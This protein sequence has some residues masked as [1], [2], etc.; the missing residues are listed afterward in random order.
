[1]KIVF[2]ITEN[3]NKATFQQEVVKI[4]TSFNQTE[5]VVKPKFQIGYYPLPYALENYYTKS[6]A[7]LTFKPITY[8][9]D[10][11]E[12]LTNGNITSK[13]VIFNSSNV[14]FYWQNNITSY[15]IYL[16]KANI[17]INEVETIDFDYRGINSSNSYGNT[18]V[19]FGTKTK[20]SNVII[21]NESGTIVLDYQL[22]DFYKKTET[23]SQ[24][25]INTALGLKLD[26]GGYVGTAQDLYDRFEGKIEASINNIPKGGNGA[27]GKVLVNSII[28]EI[29]GKIAIA[30]GV[31]ASE[32][33]EVNG[34]VKSNS[35]K[36]NLPSSITAQPNML[37][38]KPDGSRPTWYNN[39]SVGKDIAFIDDISGGLVNRK[40]VT[41]NQVL[42]PSAVNYA[43]SQITV[44]NHG[45]TIGS[46]TFCG[47]FLNQLSYMNGGFVYIPFEW[48]LAKT[49]IKAIDA[50]TLQICNNAGTAI[51][52]NTADSKNSSIDFT[53]WHI[54]LFGKLI[55][56]VPNLSRFRFVVKGYCIA[57]SINANRSFSMINSSNS[58]AEFSLPA[59]SDIQNSCYNNIDAYIDVKDGFPS[60]IGV[61]NY[62]YHNN[63]FGT[64]AS[65]RNVNII[66]RFSNYS[67]ATSIECSMLGG[68][69]NNFFANGT[70]IEIYK[71]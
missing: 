35:Y 50:N 71:S 64:F 48:R 55:I 53:K 39:S 18:L 36:F 33:L 67:E 20:I 26:K 38:P 12:V 68:S 65:P 63:A 14:G 43:T 31:E 45:K 42:T 58:I 59:I 2:N 17:G 15:G 66:S 32:K 19:S 70:V 21:P 9:P 4:N 10:I 8:N 30:L 1:M 6:E 23:Y 51:A 22:N 13:N 24:S 62:Y 34:N 49:Y 52:V 7:N 60:F 3:K 44:T 37:I 54:E 57:S 46:V 16:Q 28:S 25:Q 11:D 29:N 47:I 5:N 56:N 61:D 41:E 40:I 69:F 27:S